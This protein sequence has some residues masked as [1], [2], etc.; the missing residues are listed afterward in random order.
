[1]TEQ[2]SLSASKPAK[3]Y[4]WLWLCV[5][6]IVVVEQIQFWRAP[7]LDTDVLALLPTDEQHPE[8]LLATRQMLQHNNQRLVILLGA[9]NWQQTQAAA[10]LF[11]AELAKSPALLKLSDTGATNGATNLER[12]IEFYRPWRDRLLSVEQKTWLRTAPA[13]ELEAR[14][15]MQLYQLPGA[16]MGEWRSDPLGLWP[17]WWRERGGESKARPRDGW[18]WLS[19]A[20]KEWILLSYESRLPAFSASGAMPLTAALNR[21]EQAVLQTQPNAEVVRAGV[22]LYAEAAAAQGNQE[23]STIGFGALAAVLLLVW[24]TFRSL[25]PILLVGVSLLIGCATALSV[26]ALFFDRVHLLTL[27]FGASLVGVAE[28]YGFHYF[29]ARQGNDASARFKILRHLMPGLSLALLTSVVA[30]LALGIAPFPGLRQMAL[31]SAVG[32]VAAFLTVVC[33]FPMLDRG[34]LPTTR[35]AQKMC[36]SLM[37]WPRITANKYGA[38][39]L[40]ASIIFV[41]FGLSKLQT[42]DDIRQ[43][44]SAPKNLA[45]EQAQVA[46]LL[47]LPSGSQYFL[48]SAASP[49]L[50][51]QRDA[52]FKLSL[53]PLLRAQTLVGINA[54][55][56][57]LPSIA[58]QNESLKLVANAEAFALTAVNASTGET[59]S[60]TEFSQS[61]LLPDQFLASPAA[62]FARAQWLGEIGGQYYA[63]M[64]IRGLESNELNEV[65]SYAHGQ[66]GVRWIDRTAD[67]SALLARYRLQMGQLLLLGL[68]L[69]S[70]LLWLR[71]RNQAW[72]AVTPTIVGGLLTLALFGWLGIPLQLFS[73]LALILLLGMGVDYGIFLTEHPGDGSAWLAV[74]LAGVSTLLSFGLLALSQTPALRAFGLTMLIGELTIWLL[75]PCFRPPSTH[76]EPTCSI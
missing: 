49:E 50:L 68:A 69:V 26:T 56:D 75:T 40:L 44:Y 42:Q 8:L 48:L 54:I 11:V 16:G 21:A 18:L 22:A 14:A 15:L 62:E 45:S 20:G 4:A 71:F 39:C 6:L 51:L 25:R 13:D 35:F 12:S 19:G 70:L 10:T 7:R 2:R 1:M 65:A 55:S 17:E 60:R 73:V 61:P 9:P 74:A 29:A 41:G 46:Q 37:R 64:L 63:V 30:Y 24:C 43:L 38:L 34:P 72:R 52:A 47:N 67:T 23:M 32:L 3:L 28:D 57:W 36:A 33:W 27:V 31:F 58:A 5:V 59:L 66:V 53:T 76:P